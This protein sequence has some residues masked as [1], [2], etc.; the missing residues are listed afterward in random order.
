MTS[1]LK[2]T[3]HSGMNSPLQSHDDLFNAPQR[4][5]ELKHDETVLTLAVSDKYIFAGTHTGE[6]FVWSLATFELVK[7][8]QAH[9]RHTI[10]RS[11]LVSSGGDALVS[12]WCPKTFARLYEIY[13]PD[14]IGDVFSCAY[15]TQQD[16]VYIGAQNTSIQ[17]VKL[18][19]PSRRVPHDNPNHPDQRIDTFFDSKAIGGKST[20]RKRDERE[21]LIPPANET[22]EVYRS[23]IGNRAHSGF[24][25]SMFIAKG[26]TV[27]VD[28]D[29]EVLITGGGE[30]RI[31][32]WQIKQDEKYDGMEEWEAWE[33]REIM[34]LGEQ[35]A[36]S[37]FH[38]AIDGS[39]LYSGKK[40]GIIELWDLD[41]KQKLR[42]I[43]D[44]R[45][46]NDH[47]GDIMSLQ[48]AWGYLWSAATTGTVA[49]HS[50][51][52]SRASEKVS[53]KYRCLSRWQAHEGKILSSAC[54]TYQ[55]HNYYITGANDNN[56][57]VWRV[58]GIRE[59]AE[60][61]PDES[62]RTMLSS[63]REFVSYRTVSARPEFAEECRQGASFLCNLFK[64]LGAQVN[65]LS[66]EKLHNPV[67][68]AVFSGKLEPAER[69]KRILFYGHYDVVPADR[70][71]KSKWATDPFQMEGING[72]L[73]G[74][75]VS[76]NKG[77]IMAALYA[78]TDLLQAQQ[79]DSD[80][81]FLIEG[82]EES[83]S[84]NFRETIRKNKDLI[85]NVDYILLANSYWIDDET[86]CLTYGL[87][88]VLHATICVDSAYPDLHSGVDGS[89]M[90]DEPLADLMQVLTSLKGPRNKIMVPHFYDAVLPLTPDEEARYEEIVKILSRRNPE[91]GTVQQLKSS[92]MAR[93][94]E[95]NLTIHGTKVSGVDESVVSSHASATISFRIVPDQ[96]VDDIVASLK[97]YLRAQF[98]ELES[99]NTLTIKID[100][101][102][103]PWLGD[104][105]NQIFKTLEEAII[106]VWGEDGGRRNSSSPERDAAPDATDPEAGHGA[107]GLPAKGRKPLYIREGGS[108][109]AIRFLEKEFGA[110]VAHLPCGQ[111][112]DSAH[113]EN[114][115]IR[116]LNLF[117]SREIFGEAFRRL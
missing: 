77:P 93:W 20:P 94:R 74:R 75:G 9:K 54:T 37:V 98:A 7:R 62:E 47:Y 10:S 65:M 11:I 107:T 46:E 57:S 102:A 97:E 85:G 18:S 53:Q 117:R 92:L 84:R 82:E 23:S 116:L 59:E 44:H 109:P 12:V 27:L 8:F 80:V 113:L 81:I 33:H 4:I 50:T 101:K 83:T 108:I 13:W 99:K 21:A 45:G 96:Q 30:G 91:S 17:W 58:D 68:C 72:Y 35:D 22:L 86:P 29:E 31:K 28:P 106:K 40:R 36:Q 14:H 110:P 55:G 79:L 60:D 19:D 76:D 16:T 52:H 103:E 70:D 34:C 24:I 114:E 41:T 111:A 56:L 88:G 25:Y 51:V 42:V 115:R 66:T 49:R 15:S 32:L 73:Y 87:R 69:R 43:K 5:Q 61:N 105:N 39:F 63:L 64:R 100:N 67:V 71:G 48:M 90:L 95:P 1:S 26:P 3:L 38:I 112:T 2:S 6:I 89:H 78:V 104:P